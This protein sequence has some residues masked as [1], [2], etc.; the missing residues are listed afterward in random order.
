MNAER[1]LLVLALNSGSSSLKFGLYRVRSLHTQRLV[2]GEAESFGEETAVFH[3]ED[4]TGASLLRESA[5]L[6]SQKD[7]VIRIARLLTDLKMPAPQSV[8][9]RIVHGGPKLRHHCV[10]NDSVLDKL[11]AAVAFAPLHMPRA[12][13]VIRFAEA[14]FPALPQVACFDTSFHAH[15]P[16][17]ARVLPIP[18]ELRA[19]GVE[20]YGF[21]GLS[22]ESIVRQLGG[23]LPS[24][25]LIAHLGNGASIT[26]VKD[27]QSIDTSMGLTPTGGIVMG[28]RSG[29]LDPG[30]LVYLARRK[31]LDATQLEELVDR[32]SGLLGVSGISADLRDL[33]KVA[34]SNT[35]ARLA[36]DMFCYSAAKQLAAMSAA[37]GGVDTIVF[38][39]GVGENDAQ[40]RTLICGHLG[41]IGVRVDAARNRDAGD[42][43]SDGASRCPVRVLPSQEDE[44]IARQAWN[45]C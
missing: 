38:T 20:R 44:Q 13:S 25:L 35:D 33:H 5:A 42:P 26:A 27:G 4:P 23:A 24:K 2:T 16:D 10:I 28:T 18:H 12:L 11:N 14:H 45:L 36:I 29:D 15:M 6:P 43:I 17:L 19:D 40:V 31:K 7:A 37:L 22:C 9:H 32:R 3:A 8:G 34:H 30:V 21:H 41:V 39:G 1:E